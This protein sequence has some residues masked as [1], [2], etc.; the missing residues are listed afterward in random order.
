MFYQQK[1]GKHMSNRF[2]SLSADLVAIAEELSA[3]ADAKPVLLKALIQLADGKYQ[4]L[5]S[6]RVTKASRLAGFT[7]VINRG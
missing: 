6:G 2:G 3:V 4:H 5:Q 7:R 1:E